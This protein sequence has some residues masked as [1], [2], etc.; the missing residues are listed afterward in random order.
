MVSKEG[1]VMDLDFR[2]RCHLGC[3]GFRGLHSGCQDSRAVAVLLLVPWSFQTSQR[4]GMSELW[5][6]GVQ[7]L[8][9]G[10]RHKGGC[11]SVVQ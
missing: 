11:L 2:I 1:M 10:I 6:D 4:G 7:G 9:G 5:V 3:E 8:Q